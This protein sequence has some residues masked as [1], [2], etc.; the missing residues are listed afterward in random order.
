MY[1]SFKADENASSY[2]WERRGSV[3]IGDI[4]TYWNGGARRCS[5][6]ANHTCPLAA[7]CSVW[8]LRNTEIPGGFSLGLSVLKAELMLVC[9]N[10]V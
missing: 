3:W 4:L 8:V 1:N 7:K 10:V 2:P 6:M 5:A 9:V